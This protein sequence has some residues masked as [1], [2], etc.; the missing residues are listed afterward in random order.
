MATP[1]TFAAS[2]LRG[3]ATTTHRKWILSCSLTRSEAD[4][5]CLRQ[6]WSGFR[7]N[8]EFAPAM[9]VPVVPCYGRWN[10][11]F[12]HPVE[13]RPANNAWL[14]DFRITTVMCLPGTR[15][16]FVRPVV[17]LCDVFQVLN[18]VVNV[19]FYTA[20]EQ[21]RSSRRHRQ[22]HWRDRRLESLKRRHFNH[23]GSQHSS[24]GLRQQQYYGAGLTVLRF[25]IDL[26]GNNFGGCHEVCA[27]ARRSNQDFHYNITHE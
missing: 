7:W 27:Q 17:E 2:H 23:R 26:R 8:T 24:A 3:V 13:T 18:S 5:E 14:R 22:V 16:R 4:W 10:I 20:V 25:G 19:P 1:E 9:C 21:P 11:L 6:N 15:R 12:E